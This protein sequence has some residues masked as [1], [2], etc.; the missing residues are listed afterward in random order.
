M[1]SGALDHS[2]MTSE[3][4]GTGE[5]IDNSSTCKDWDVISVK[6]PFTAG[7]P[8]FACLY[9]GAPSLSAE[10]RLCSWSSNPGSSSYQMCDL[11]QGM[12]FFFNL[13]IWLSWVLVVARGV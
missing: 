8:G 12:L 9:L 10:M 13:F 5:L 11:V 1:S 2:A 6:L 4:V 3:Q 7:E